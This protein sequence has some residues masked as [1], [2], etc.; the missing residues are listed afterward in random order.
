MQADH[1]S[2][3]QIER[4]RLLYEEYKTDVQQVA[5]FK[6][7]DE[8][9]TLVRQEMVDFLEKYLNG[10]ISTKQFKEIFDLKT[11]SQWNTFGLKGL[12]GG[13]FLNRLI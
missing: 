13:M 4:W 9:R 2:N 3:S 11:R 1:L 5:N 12:S 8:R 7:L 10:E 6:K